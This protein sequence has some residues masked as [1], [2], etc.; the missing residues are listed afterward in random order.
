MVNLWKRVF[1]LADAHCIDQLGFFLDRALHAGRFKW[2][3]GYASSR[4]GRDMNIFPKDLG[5]N[6][7]VI[8]SGQFGQ[9]NLAR[10][11][12]SGQITICQIKWG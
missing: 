8:W 5:F 2:L 1:F 12:W 6:V 11:I 4:N 9:V 7:G 3:Q 10:S